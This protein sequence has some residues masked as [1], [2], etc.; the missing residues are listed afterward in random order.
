MINL[1]APT[2]PR[3]WPPAPESDAPDVFALLGLADDGTL[4]ILDLRPGRH[5]VLRVEAV[6]TRDDP[7]QELRRRR[8]DALLRRR[9]AT[10]PTHRPSDPAVPAGYLP[11]EDAARE[12]DLS[13]P[14]LSRLIRTGV[15]RSKKIKHKSF[16]LAADVHAAK[17]RPNQRP[18]RR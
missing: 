10:I 6:H 15:V 11:A 12:L 17:N 5:G 3:G 2:P 18:N 7:A 9:T 1:P 4:T 8:N 16:C 13:R 14:S